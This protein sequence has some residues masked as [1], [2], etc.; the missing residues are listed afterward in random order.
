MSTRLHL[1]RARKRH[2]LQPLQPDAAARLSAADCAAIA[3]DDEAETHRIATVLLIAFACG[4]AVSL[5]LI[6]AR[7]IEG[8]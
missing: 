3:G 5:A 1:V 7:Y 4:F 6:V 2:A 8:T